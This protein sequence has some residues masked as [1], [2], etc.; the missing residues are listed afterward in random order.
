MKKSQRIQRLAAKT[1]MALMSWTLLAQ[2]PTSSAS[3]EV[4]SVKLA[5]PAT[6]QVWQITGGPGTPT[7]SRFIAAN[8]PLSSL[9]FRA[10]GLQAHQLDR[11]ASLEDVRYDITATVADGSTRM[12]VGAMLQKLLT[13]RLRL[14]THFEERQVPGYEL[15]IAKSGLK[16][17]TAE[18]IAIPI[19][20]AASSEAG[21]P[22]FT[23]GPDGVPELA[24]GRPMW[25]ARAVGN[26]MSIVGRVQS[27]GSL[28]KLLEQRVG[29]PIADLT[30][31]AGT[32]D[33]RL[34]FE[35]D[36]RPLLVAGDDPQFAVKE[37]EPAPDLAGAL[38]SQ[39]GLHLRAV[40]RPATVLVVDGYNRT[41]TPN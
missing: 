19:S 36:G 5:R 35:P 18:A 16:M 41:P 40:K 22:K 8:A 32:Y 9:L 4:A 37:S 27:M 33:F 10:F 2:Q 11:A 17:T 12:Q 3:F 31:L 38:E 23:T 34:L 24:A 30:A 1:V 25:V 21:P 15:T 20:G 14:R 6:A 13:D 29:Y 39:L 26:A 28:I 7:P